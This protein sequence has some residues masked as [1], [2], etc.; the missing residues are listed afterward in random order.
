MIFLRNWVIY[1]PLYKYH[2]GT[3]LRHLTSCPLTVTNLPAIYFGQ[4]IVQIPVVIEQVNPDIKP[5]VTAVG[6]YISGFPETGEWRVKSLSS[7][8]VIRAWLRFSDYLQ[9]LE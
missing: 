8:C 9:K 5:L 6:Q 3:N 4:N 2:F 1:E 7:S